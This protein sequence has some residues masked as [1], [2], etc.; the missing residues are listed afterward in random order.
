MTSNAIDRHQHRQLAGHW[1]TGVSLVTSLGPEG[2]T[3]CTLNALTSLSLEP[4][5]L[6]A[7]FDLTARTLEAIRSSGRFCVN[8]LA[9]DQEDVSR[10]FATKAEMSEK[11][12]GLDYRLEHGAPVLT[13]LL[14][15][16]VCAVHDE[17]E[18]GDHAIVIGRPIAG[19]TDLE[20][21]PLLFFRSAYRALK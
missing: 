12:E 13:G 9:S 3:G 7:C 1:A 19:E 20:A 17:L 16:I 14:A 8:I 21:E 2:P 6:L 11:F 4:P 10:R 5:L 18:G 15:S